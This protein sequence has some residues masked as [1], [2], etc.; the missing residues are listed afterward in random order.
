MGTASGLR[1][2]GLLRGLSRAS[3]R[4]GPAA[5][6]PGPASG[7]RLAGLSARGGSPRAPRIVTVRY[8]S[9]ERPAS[10]RARLPHMADRVR[11][12]RVDVDVLRASEAL[13]AIEA[14]VRARRGGAVFTPNVD[15][16]VKLERDPA[17]RAAYDAA[18]LRLADG[19]PLVWASRLLGSPLPERVAGADLVGPLAARA[20]ARGW[21]LYLL[22]GPPGVA[23]RAARVLAAAGVT[24]AGHDAPWIDEP[25]CRCDSAARATSAAAAERVR[26]ARADLVYVGLGAPKQELWIHRHRDTIRPAVAIGVGASLSYVAGALPRA[27]RWMARAGLEWAYRLT[28]EPG[29]LWR[30]YLVDDLSFARI[31]LRSWRAA[32]ADRPAARPH[33]VVWPDQR[34]PKCRCRSRADGRRGRRCRIR[35]MS[36]GRGR[37]E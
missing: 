7:V 1:A 6:R 8:T 18:E 15:Q 12:G 31:L 32:A 13:D 36:R 26:A 9:L 27:P 22:G 3:R 30:R 35:A 37:P 2:A 17:L 28:R 29:R 19:M 23:A 34:S 21:R 5:A 25:P 24:I 4:T 33:A 11:I 16:L 14:L 10:S 20:A